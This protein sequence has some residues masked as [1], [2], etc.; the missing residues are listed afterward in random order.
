MPAASALDGRLGGVQ[1]LWTLIDV[2]HGF[3]EK[4][5]V[6]FLTNVMRVVDEFGSARASVAPVLHSVHGS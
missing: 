4:L 2:A 5:P 1:N 3:S 6:R